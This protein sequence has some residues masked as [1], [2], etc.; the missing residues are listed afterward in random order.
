MATE[1]I[2]MLTCAG[3]LAGAA[4][5]AEPFH[6]FFAFKNSMEHKLPEM[7]AQA[8]VLA[9]IGFGGYDHREVDAL[10]EAL[11]AL[12]ERG[13]KLYTIYFRVDIDTPEQPWTPDLDAALPLLKGR[14]T[15]LWCNTHS[16]RFEPSDPAG[17]EHAVPIF[18][19]LAD[20]VAPWGV[21]VAP[22]LVPGEASVSEVAY[23]IHKS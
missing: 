20:K 22:G 18:Q 13:L 5:E 8:A 10:E 14:N 4:Q 21:P 9:E 15:I 3:L 17:D 23:G 12:D 2:I 11:R 1:S 7:T 19:A 6:P 16:K